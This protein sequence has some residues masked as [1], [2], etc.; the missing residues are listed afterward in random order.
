MA[1]TRLLL[2]EWAK[3]IVARPTCTPFG[4]IF[5]NTVLG[6][7]RHFLT[8]LQS[9]NIGIWKLKELYVDNQQALKLLHSLS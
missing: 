3:S 7:N 4:A 8:S 5:A 1:W 6:R 2:R 9:G